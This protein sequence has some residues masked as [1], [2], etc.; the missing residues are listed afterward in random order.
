MIDR[1][2]RRQ[3]PIVGGLLGQS[4]LNTA[5]RPLAIHRFWPGILA[6]SVAVLVLAGPAEAQ[7]RRTSAR[8]PA[9]MSDASRI[10]KSQKDLDARYT[11][12][13]R[14][15]KASTSGICVGCDTP[16]SMTVKSLRTKKPSGAKKPSRRSGPVR[17]SARR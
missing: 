13:D 10:A 5:T 7:S 8:A 14:R 15:A 16:T 1:R 12:W 4:Q 2:A 9:P 6:A 11:E 17:A 3:L